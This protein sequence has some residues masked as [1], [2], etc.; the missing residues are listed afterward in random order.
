MK[1]NGLLCKW[2]NGCK[3]CIYQV[4]DEVKKCQECMFEKKCNYE[5]LPET[6]EG[7]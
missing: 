3:G 1:C 5:S 6:E 4:S 7:K 2:H